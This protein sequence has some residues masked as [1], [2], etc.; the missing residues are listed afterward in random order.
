MSLL[1][2]KCKQYNPFSKLL[3][4]LESGERLSEEIE[5]LPRAPRASVGFAVPIYDP[6]LLPPP[7]RTEP[8]PIPTSFQVRAK[9]WTKEAALPDLL[10]SLKRFGPVDTQ[11]ALIRRYGVSPFTMAKWLA[12]W[13]AAGHIVRG[14]RGAEVAVNLPYA[15]IPKYAT[16]KVR[17]HDPVQLG[18]E[19]EL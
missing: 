6:P 18:L 17:P 9:H 16:I 13:E 1:A 19:L 12:E 5:P 4:I 14:S 11:R 15:Y 10:S 3:H 2:E 8:P 7:H